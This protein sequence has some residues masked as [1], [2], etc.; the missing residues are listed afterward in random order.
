MYVGT[1]DDI[2]RLG[3]DENEHVS[4]HWPEFSAKDH[5]GHEHVIIEA[6]SEGVIFSSLEHSIGGA[7]SVAVL[8][9][10]VSDEERK[11]A[12]ATAFSFAGRPYDFEFDF[13][14]TDMLVCTEVVFRTYGGNS[15]PISF[16]LERI[17][18]RETMPA[19][20]LVKKFNEEYGTDDAQF[21]F[22]AFIDGDEHTETSSFHTDVESFRETE[23]RP[24]SSFTQGSKLNAFKDIGPL[25]WVLLSLTILAAVVLVV[26]PLNRRVRAKAV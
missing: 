3:L 4:K 8:R 10:K 19:I 24:A 23:Q 25:G 20:N 14:T 22:V 6:V 18:G 15:G 16:P 12:I 9:P 13:E 21:E 7:D 2:R 5:E 11:T 17:M 26:P 1:A